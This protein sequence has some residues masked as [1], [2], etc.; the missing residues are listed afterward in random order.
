MYFAAALGV[1]MLAAPTRG[2]LTGVPKSNQLFWA[3]ITLKAEKGGPPGERGLRTNS[4]TWQFFDG[5]KLRLPGLVQKHRNRQG[6]EE[7]LALTALVEIRPAGKGRV[8]IEVT[9]EDEATALTEANKQRI[10]TVRF[11]NVD[12]VL[13]DQLVVLDLGKDENTGHGY[14]VTLKVLE[15]TRTKPVR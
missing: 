9:V 13:L 7:E 1:L 12:T 11:R 4:S 14:E 6:V 3:E 10:R 15:V 2:E 5:Q 8:R